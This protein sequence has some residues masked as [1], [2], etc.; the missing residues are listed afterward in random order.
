[1]QMHKLP[2]CQACSVCAKH[3][4]PANQLTF[5]INNL[6]MLF[7]LLTMLLLAG[8]TRFANVNT[9]VCTKT[10]TYLAVYHRAS[11][12]GTLFGKKTSAQYT[13][14]IIFSMGT[15]LAP[16]RACSDPLVHDGQPSERL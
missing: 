16:L 10:D 4:S 14:K 1:M 7:S 6:D 13:M 12:A 2:V 3:L 8:I 9:S 11:Q 15:L 5:Y